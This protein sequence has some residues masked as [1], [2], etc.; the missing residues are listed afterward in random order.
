LQINAFDK[1]RDLKPEGIF[2]KALDISPGV[3]ESLLL[4]R[5]ILSLSKNISSRS[6]SFLVQPYFF[7]NP[8][9]SS[10]SFRFLFNPRWISLHA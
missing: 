10:T 5:Q 6:G 3:L 4:P 7:K 9:I 2:A 8:S 1:S